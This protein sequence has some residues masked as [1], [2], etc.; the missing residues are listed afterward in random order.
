MAI[1]TLTQKPN[2]MVPE[3]ERPTRTI[4]EGR[5]NLGEQ[6]PVQT[7]TP[8]EQESRNNRTREQLL[9]EYNR[10]SGLSEQDFSEELQVLRKN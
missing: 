2:N 10:L 8:Q 9:A 6:I 5:P 7:I 3:R 1:D 4:P